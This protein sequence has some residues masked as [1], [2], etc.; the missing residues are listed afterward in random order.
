M[1]RAPNRVQRRRFLRGRGHGLRGAPHIDVGRGKPHEERA[2]EQ[3]G[4]QRIAD[5]VVQRGHHHAQGLVFAV[6]KAREQSAGLVVLRAAVHV[7]QHNH[8]QRA[9]VLKARERLEARV[10][11]G[12]LHIRVQTGK[13]TRAGCRETKRRGEQA[14]H[15]ALSAARRAGKHG[16][17]PQRQADE[18]VHGFVVVK[19]PPGAFKRPAHVADHLRGRRLIGLRT[20]GIVALVGSVPAANQLRGAAVDRKSKEIALKGLL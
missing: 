6:L 20:A 18:Q 19:R 17:V 4:I 3:T 5:L 2:V 10:L 11:A 13:A 14:N 15:R 16:K 9:V 8:A 1:E 7:V 12:V